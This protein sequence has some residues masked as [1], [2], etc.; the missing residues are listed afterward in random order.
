L[1]IRPEDGSFCPVGSSDDPDLI[2]LVTGELARRDRLNLSD[3][4]RPLLYAV[5]TQ[6]RPLTSL[7]TA[8]AD[9]LRLLRQLYGLEG[10]TAKRGRRVTVLRK[11][12]I[13]VTRSGKSACVVTHGRLRKSAAI[14]AEPLLLETEDA[15]RIEELIA[16]GEIAW[17]R[18]GGDGIV[19]APT[20]T[21][22][23]ELCCRNIARDRP[24]FFRFSPAAGAQVIIFKEEAFQADWWVSVDHHWARRLGDWAV[25]WFGGLGRHNHIGRSNHVFMELEVSE[26]K[27]TVRFNRLSATA[28]FPVEAEV[29][30]E[31]AAVKFDSADLAPVLYRLGQT[32]PA[33]GIIIAGNRHAVVFDYAT[34][35]GSFLIAVPAHD[36]LTDGADPT[37]F[38]RTTA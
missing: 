37:L 4:V 24:E 25:Q 18:D 16:T 31:V 21:H 30:G 36:D 8:A 2:K 26:V 5:E 3:K 19:P 13:I 11:D 32:R 35:T 7:P 6:A 12:T 38:E 20:D 27:L 10:A 14:P 22:A 33:T 23:Y 1:L 9:R 34:A 15:I 17:L 29:L 28:E